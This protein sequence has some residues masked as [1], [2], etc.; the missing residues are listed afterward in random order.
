MPMRDAL[1]AGL[2]VAV[3]AAVSL[4]SGALTGPALAATPQEQEGE[5]GEGVAPLPEGMTLEEVLEFAAGPP[6]AGFPDPVPDD[7]V[8]AFVLFDQLEYR[9]AGRNRPDELGWDVQGWVGGDYNRFWWKNEGESSFDG[10]AEGESETD[11][12]YSRL[13]SPFWSAQAGVQ[14]ASTWGDGG[15]GDRWSAVVALQGLAP[16]QFEVDASLYLSEAGDLTFEVEAEYG[17][18]ITQR[19]VLQPRAE[20]ALSFQE[21]PARRLGSGITSAELDL[22]LRYEIRRKFAPYV[23]VR[24]G[25]LLGGTADLAEAAGEPRDRRFV[26]AGVRLAI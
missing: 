21:V 18:R 16:Y 23:G 10:A 12:L 1:A 11:L 6:P 25:F 22:R 15:Y 26:V 19:L 17:L 8:Y 14:Y 20:L 9:F 2:A 4:C 13:I 3:V 5:A 24:W 7:A